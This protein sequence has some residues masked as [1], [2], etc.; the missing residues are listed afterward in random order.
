[1]TTKR[2]LSKSLC[3]IGLLVSS[4]AVLTACSQGAAEGA[5]VGGTVGAGTGAAIGAADGNAGRGAAIGAASGATAGAV[6]GSQSQ[7]PKASDKEQEMFMRR[8]AEAM[9]KQEGE[10]DDLRRQ[11]YHDEYYRQRYGS[12]ENS[13]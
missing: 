6:V 4:A 11:L 12:V 8:Q 13:N 3:T 2:I 5:V 9:Q 1:M 7:P 10:L